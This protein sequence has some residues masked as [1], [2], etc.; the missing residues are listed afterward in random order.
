MKIAEAYNLFM[1]YGRG[2]RN[3]ARE[4]IVKL[5]DC[6][7]S[8]LL[9][10]IGDLELEIMSRMDVVR[11][12]TA[13]VDRGVGVNRQYSVLMALKVFCKFCRQ[14]LKLN[15]LDPDKEIQLPQRPAPYVVYLSN[16]EVERL[17]NCLETRNFT[18]RRMRALVEVLLTTGL[19]ISEALSL[20]RTP[21][22]N[23]STE[24]TI[25]GKGGKRRTVFFP[26]GTAGW[27]KRFLY[28]RQDDYPAVFV[29]TGIPRRWD[30]NDLSKYF[31]E[32]K[33]KAGID[34]KLTP[35]ILRH[36]YCTN[37]RDNGAD[38]TLIKELTTSVRAGG[39]MKDGADRKGDRG[40]G[41]INGI[42]AFL[43]VAVFRAAL[44]VVLIPVQAIFSLSQTKGANVPA[45]PAIPR[46]TGR[47]N[48]DK[49]LWAHSVTTRT[50][51]CKLD[52]GPRRRLR[53]PGFCSRAANHGRRSGLGQKDSHSQLRRKHCKV[54]EFGNLARVS[55]LAAARADRRYWS[56]DQPCEACS[57]SSECCW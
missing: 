31:K 14:V 48:D 27:I 12:R 33:W 26:E 37:L 34:K 44:A 56:G 22:E 11:L 51:R 28:F 21:F 36:T 42:F 32:L 30:R 5:R 57:S 25:V 6:F 4:T 17:R 43:F 53:W 13:M 38:I 49:P 45:E 54:V 10:V 47:D 23:G 55:S 46:L 19:R 8:W 41:W 50:S 35:H 1:S 9:P 29:T 40:S 15:C 39:A 18:G 16:E 7:R 3:Y 24:V 2:E 20:D 52:I